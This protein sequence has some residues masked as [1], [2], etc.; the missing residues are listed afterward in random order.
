[1]P[2]GAF[3]Q[4]DGGIEGIVPNNEL[5]SRRINKPD[6]VVQVGD[7]IE[8]KIIELRPEE[9]RMTLSIRQV[10]EDREYGEFEAYD[11]GRSEDAVTIG[12]MVGDFGRTEDEDKFVDEEN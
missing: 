1:V 5:T 2:F 10:L 4:L 11:R 7:H 3:V 8:V 12:D 6:E 9:R